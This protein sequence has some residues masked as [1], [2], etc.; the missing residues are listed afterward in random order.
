MVVQIQRVVM[1]VKL[2][3]A[4]LCYAFLI[5]GLNYFILRSH[6]PVGDAFLLG[7]VIYA[8]FETTN[9]ALFQKWSWLTVVLD[10]LWGGILFALTTFIVSK[11]KSF[12]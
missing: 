9:L 8:V 5:F 1:Q 7:L 6:R 3:P 4:L 11:F 12:F 10:T 2:W